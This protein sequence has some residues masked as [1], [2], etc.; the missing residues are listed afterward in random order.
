M[1]LY[2]ALPHRG[3]IIAMT[4]ILMGTANASDWPQF[5][6]PQASGIS[7]PKKAPTTWDDNSGENIL[8]KHEIP[9]LSLSAP[10]VHNGRVYITTAQLTVETGLKLGPRGRFAYKDSKLEHYW[11]I[12]CFDAKTGGGNI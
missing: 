6:G 4:L 3:F 1:R 2:P 7:G 9:G 10:V 12:F 11:K 8:W 5:R